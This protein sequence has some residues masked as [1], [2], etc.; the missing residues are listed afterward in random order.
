MDNCPLILFCIPVPNIFPNFKIKIMKNML[1]LCLTFLLSSQL[2]SQT[3]A[4]GGNS[5]KSQS[6]EF[7]VWGNCGMCKKT[8]EK[9]AKSVNGVQTAIWDKETDIITVS[10]DSKATDL[11]KIHRSIAKSGYDTDKV[12]GDD[13]AYKNLPGCCQYDRRN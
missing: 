6:A 4:D 3:S 7:K 8:I 12:R 10:F 11:K 13:N 2:F 5:T 1:I 9:A